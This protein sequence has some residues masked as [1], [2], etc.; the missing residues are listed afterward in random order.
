MARPLERSTTLRVPTLTLVNVLVIENAG[1]GDD[2]G[3]VSDAAFC[4][5]GFTL[6]D[7]RQLLDVRQ[8]VK[9]ANPVF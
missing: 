1:S 2:T 5:Q 9:S 6:S 3:D 8:G 7:I 4:T